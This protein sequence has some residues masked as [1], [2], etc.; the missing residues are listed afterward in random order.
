M[1]LLAGALRRPAARPP[2]ACLSTLAHTCR[3]PAAL[4][5]P[6]GLSSGA[7]S[8]S[9]RQVIAFLAGLH[10]SGLFRP[11]LIV[12]PATVLRQWLRELRAWWPLFRVALLHD[13]ARSGAAGGGRPSRAR[14]I[15]DIAQ[16]GGVRGLLVGPA[17][18][19]SR[20]WV[21]PTPCQLDGGALLISSSD[22]AVP[23]SPAPPCFALLPAPPQ[24][25]A[26]VL[27]TTYETMRLQRGELLGVEWGYVVLDEGH[28]IRWAQKVSRQLGFLATVQ[29]CWR[30]VVPDEGHRI[31][32]AALLGATGRAGC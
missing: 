17:T 28:K 24:S 23:T 22:A 10:H 4:L 13:S 8:V 1:H 14:L 21:A 26:G 3:L 32:W 29:G 5:A 9:P 7:S 31:R 19:R 11:S 25:D 20:C 16:V 6:P 15:R 27:L 30:H 18:W 12:C 2:S